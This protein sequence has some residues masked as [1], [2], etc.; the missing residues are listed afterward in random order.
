[1]NKLGKM[2]CF[3]I[4]ITLKMEPRYAAVRY[5]RKKSERKVLKNNLTIEQ[6]RAF[7]A[8]SPTKAVKG[9]INSFVGFLNMANL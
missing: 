6:A 9:K 2:L 3:L 1:M 4:V 7:C 5:F 8:D